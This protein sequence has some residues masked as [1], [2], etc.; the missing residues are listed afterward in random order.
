MAKFAQTAVHIAANDLFVS[1]FANTV[2]MQMSAEERD[3]TT[4]ASGGYRQ[5]ITSLA[6]FM[7]SV[8]GFQDFAT[9]G[10]DVSF[11]GQNIGASAGVWSVAVPG[12]TVG[13]VAYFGQARTL[14]ITPFRG[15]AGDVAGFD[16]SLSGTSRL[17]RGVVG[18]PYAS[19]TVTGNGT[20]T[21][22]AG[23][24]ATQSLYAAFHL[25]SVTGTP[26]SVQFVVQTDDNVGMSTPTTRITS[27][28]FTAAGSQFASVAGAFSG[29][30]H[31]R[32]NH[33]ITTFTAAVFS[34]VVGVTTTIS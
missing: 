30:T 33:T 32:V 7:V 20:A 23:P 2:D 1:S 10:P 13:D 12:E 26:G 18:A 29:E 27:T 15:A 34:V 17:V 5:K 4:F 3:V 6:T 14:G 8:G 16:L 19:R 11:P 31:V 28:A 24:S 9:T 25:H 21:A 22:L